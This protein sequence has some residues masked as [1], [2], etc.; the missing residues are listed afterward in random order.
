[1]MLRHNAP[2]QQ[3]NKATSK[4]G[5]KRMAANM[6]ENTTPSYLQLLHQ[7]MPRPI[8]PV[9]DAEEGHTKYYFSFRSVKLFIDKK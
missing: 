7:S 3:S 6:W 2:S 5:L 4:A 9:V 1:M 8:K